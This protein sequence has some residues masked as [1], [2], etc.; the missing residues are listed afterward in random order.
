MGENGKKI[1]QYVKA[2]DVIHKVCEEYMEAFKT[3]LGFESELESIL[4]RDIHEGVYDRTFNL[5]EEAERGFRRWGSW[6]ERTPKGLR[7]CS[8]KYSQRN[9]GHLVERVASEKTVTCLKTL[10]KWSRKAYEVT[11]LFDGREHRG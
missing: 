8:L 6:R 3:G 5:N 1:E 9:H 7:D 11:C 4:R 10:F 2:I